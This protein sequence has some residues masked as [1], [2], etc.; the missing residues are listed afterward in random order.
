MIKVQN[1]IATREPVPQFLRG[2]AAESLA[3]LS[4]TDPA[5]GVSDAAW[6]PE[7]VTYPELP[8]GYKLGD[9]TLTVDAV[10][11]M[12]LVTYDVV[13]K[14]AEELE[15][16]QEALGTRITKLAFLSRFTDAEAVALDLASIGATVEA[17]TLRR[18][19]AKV[20]AASF[21]D[22]SREDTRL[23]VQALEPIGILSA[24]RAAEIL[25]APIQP[26]EVPQ[27]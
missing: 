9:E 18:Y 4:W 15:A 27:A 7:E 11:R 1:N 26:H 8:D 12:V 13:P 19:T 25:D 23:G 2:L 3:D 20:N 22:L 14:T 17:A 6:W 24:G 10:R 5:L 21:I 16:E